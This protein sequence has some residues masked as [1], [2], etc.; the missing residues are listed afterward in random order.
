MEEK[1]SSLKKTEDLFTISTQQKAAKVAGFTCLFTTAIVVITNF[2]IN[3]HLNVSGNAA[4]TARNILAHESL[5]RLSIVCNLI[6]SAGIVVLLTA[7]YII[8]KPV[9][10]LLALIAAFL[11]LLYGVAWVFIALNSFIA[12]RLLGSDDYLRVFETDRLQALA[13]IY[14]SGF[15]G[16]YVGLLFWSLA[17][18]VCSWLWLKSNYIP[19]ALAAFGLIFSGWCTACTIAFII[20]PDFAKAVNAWWFDSGMVIFEIILSFWLLFKGLRLSGITLM[21][22]N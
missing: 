13:K 5:F 2:T 8:L 7:L 10:R 1:I 4:E 16:Y 14:L 12:L 20:C 17:S 15:D 3:A 21:K 18:T 6:Y 11:R 9:N 22:P 19:R